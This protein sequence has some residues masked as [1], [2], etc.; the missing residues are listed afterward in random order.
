MKISLLNR[1]SFAILLTAFAPL[2]YWGKLA[3]VEFPTHFSLLSG[4]PDNW[5]G[6]GDML[7]LMGVTAAIYVLLVLCC[8]Y[9]RMINYPAKATQ[10]DKEKLFPLGVVL[11]QRLNWMLM[12]LF[13]LMIN[14]SALMAIGVMEKFPVYLMWISL[15]CILAAVIQFIVLVRRAV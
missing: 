1:I 9:P 8:R 12:L 13:S 3:G 5:G 15:L 2:T 10:E 6:R 4:A 11:A 7:I 14:C